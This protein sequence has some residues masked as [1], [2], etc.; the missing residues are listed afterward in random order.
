MFK[1]TRS[2][3]IG[4]SLAAIVTLGGAVYGGTAIAGGV[5]AASSVSAAAAQPGIAQPAALTQTTQATDAAQLRA[6]IL[7]MLKDRMGITGTPA[8][9]I[10]DQMIAR[11][12]SAGVK[13]NL[14]NMLDWCNQ[15]WDS[16]GNGGTYPRGMMGGTGGYYGCPGLNGTTPSGTA[17][18]SAAPGSAAPGGITRGG[19]MRGWG[20]S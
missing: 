8:E 1:S 10:A 18:N 4:L 11:M 7:D 2:K 20:V 6:A 14:Q 5:S 16:N 9:Q 15:Y 12:Q 13:G 3:V 17:P 19:M